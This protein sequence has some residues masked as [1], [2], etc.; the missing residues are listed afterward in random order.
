MNRNISSIWVEPRS[1]CGIV[2]N[3]KVSRWGRSLARMTATFEKCAAFP[4]IF[5]KRWNNNNNS[6]HQN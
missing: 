6:Q 3:K 4:G 2:N 1:I 5:I